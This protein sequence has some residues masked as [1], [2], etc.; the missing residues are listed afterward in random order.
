[1]MT[2]SVDGQAVEQS[3]SAFKCFHEIMMM[4]A[5]QELDPELLERLGDAAALAGVRRLPMRV[6]CA[7]LAWHALKEALTSDNHGHTVSTE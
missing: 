3:L 6:K 7:T 2:D 1:M 4:P 5:T